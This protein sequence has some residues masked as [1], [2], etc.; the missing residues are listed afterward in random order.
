MVLGTFLSAP[1]LYTS[2]KMIAIKYTPEVRLHYHSLVEKTIYDACGVSIPCG[3]IKSSDC[4][5]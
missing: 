1:M 4:A 2:A 3:V 5:F